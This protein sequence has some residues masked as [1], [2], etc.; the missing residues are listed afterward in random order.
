MPRSPRFEL[1][2][3]QTLDLSDKTKAGRH[4]HDVF[5]VKGWIYEV[6]LIFL[7]RK[8]LT[9]T[10]AVLFGVEKYLSFNCH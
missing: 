8:V 3:C 7:E 10:M 9:L 2:G 4:T 1:L 6:H 5:I